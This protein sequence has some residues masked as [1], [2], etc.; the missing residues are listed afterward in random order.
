MEPA[1]VHPH[2]HLHVHFSLHQATVLAILLALAAAAAFGV[3][4]ALQHRS[5]NQEADATPLDPS[6]L[7]KLVRNPLWLIGG[8]ADI[9]GLAFQ[10]FALNEA[11][12]VLV[13]PL[14][15]G[16]ILVATP[17]GA[18]FD[19]RRVTRRELTLLLSVVIGLAAFMTVSRPNEGARILPTHL[20]VALTGA[21][22]AAIG[23]SLLG[24][25]RVASPS[26]RRAALIAL[27]GGI[28]LG[29]SSA[30]IKTFLT[31]FGRHGLGVL[32][33]PATYA[34]IV[35]GG[36]ALVLTQ[37]AF[38]AGPL[39]PVLAILTVTEPVIGVVVGLVGLNERI[40]RGPTSVTLELLTAVATIT[41]VTLLCMNAGHQAPPPDPP[42]P[43]P[44]PEGRA[45]FDG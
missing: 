9:L 33:R 22:I 19:G 12:L 27:A 28:A 31:L 36:A 4:S 5:S 29:S 25:S 13:E 14:L 42:A 18:W 3:S 17:L 7:L 41:A 15:C 6:L 37:N 26:R 44:G 35:L 10:A 34:L 38:Q 43:G 20:V 40:A 45:S 11:S 8:V 24:A 39:G 21:S 16:A 2:L 30:L 23:L 32:G 1:I